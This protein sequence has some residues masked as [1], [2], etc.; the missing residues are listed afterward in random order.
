MLWLL[1]LAPMPFA[2][3][4]TIIKM[5]KEQAK[6]QAPLRCIA[7]TFY[8]VRMVLFICF[9][10]A[11]CP[12]PHHLGSIVIACRVTRQFSDNRNDDLY[13]LYRFVLKSHSQIWFYLPIYSIV[14]TKRFMVSVCI[15][16]HR[17]KQNEEK[18]HGIDRFIKMMLK[19][20]RSAL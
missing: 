7:W 3:R 1:L 20:C 4:L 18:R 12:I 5:Q 8:L 15:K 17:A 13:L 6:W 14:I 9:G 16:T 19:V 10:L 11:L 2:K